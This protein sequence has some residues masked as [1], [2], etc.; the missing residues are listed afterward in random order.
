LKPLA[1]AEIVVKVSIAVIVDSRGVGHHRQGPGVRCKR[2]WSPI[3]D[4]DAGILF[5]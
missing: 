5:R 1:I 2:R 3:E 4:D